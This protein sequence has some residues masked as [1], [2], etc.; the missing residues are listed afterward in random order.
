MIHQMGNVLDTL[1]KCAE[2]FEAKYA[3]DYFEQPPLFETGDLVALIPSGKKAIYLNVAPWVSQNEDFS[4]VYPVGRKVNP[5][6]YIP[7]LTKDLKLLK[8]KHEITPD[9]KKL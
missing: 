5:F 9:D 3:A 1:F 8:K 7:W 6:G 4:Y 2:K